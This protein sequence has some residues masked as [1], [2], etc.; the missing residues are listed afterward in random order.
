M[1]GRLQGLRRHHLR[2][3]HAAHCRDHHAIARRQV[4]LVTRRLSEHALRRLLVVEV[5]SKEDSYGRRLMVLGPLYRLGRNERVVLGLLRATSNGRDGGQTVPI[6]VVL[7]AGLRRVL[8]VFQPGLVRLFYH[9][10]ACV[11]SEV[12]ILFLRRERL[13]ERSKRG[14]NSVAL[15]AT[16]SPF[17]PHPSFEQSVVMHQGVDLLFRRLD[18]VR[19]GSEVVCGGCRVQFPFRGVFLTSFRVEGSN[20]RVRR[21]EGGTRVNGLLMVLS[22]D[23]AFNDRR[24]TARRP[25]FHGLI[26]VF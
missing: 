9:E 5:L 25:G 20:A 14:F 13:R 2:D 8:V 4:N 26:G 15:S 10:V 18:S 23:T 22:A 12:A 19:V 6:R 24:I 3:D 21:R 7:F 17:L 1:T 16:S 11:V